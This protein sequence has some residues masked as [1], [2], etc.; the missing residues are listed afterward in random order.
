M[1]FSDTLPKASWS[2]NAYS[3]GGIIGHLA[4]G[5]IYA[6]RG[7]DEQLPII[8]TPGKTTIANVYN[9]GDIISSIP[10]SLAGGLIGSASGNGRISLA[11]SFNSGDIGTGFYGIGGL[12]GV[13]GAKN[14]GLVSGSDQIDTTIENAYNTGEISLVPPPAAQAPAYNTPY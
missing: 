3:I 13:N 2:Y 11:T 7:Y 6:E 8:L 9:T 14:S 5:G 10:I 4:N 12:I 1:D